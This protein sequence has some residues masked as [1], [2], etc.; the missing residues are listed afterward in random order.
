MT[1]IYMHEFEEV[2]ADDYRDYLDDALD[3]SVNIF[4]QTT[5]KAYFIESNNEPC[6]KE[7]RD[8]YLA[9]ISQMSERMLNMRNF[10]E[11]VTTTAAESSKSSDTTKVLAI[12]DTAKSKVDTSA[13]TLSNAPNNKLLVLKNYQQLDNAVSKLALQYKINANAIETK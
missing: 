10:V 2:H 12:V 8:R 3:L 9:F 11:N 6:D 13:T 7:L 1:D 5:L 4:Y